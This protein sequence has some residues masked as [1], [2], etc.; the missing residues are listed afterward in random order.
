MNAITDSP[1]MIR[2]KKRTKRD[3]LNVHKDGEMGQKGTKC[4][5]PFI[6]VFVDIVN[7]IFSF[8]SRCFLIQSGTFYERQFLKL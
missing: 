7:F 4:V 5:V 8:F 3:P 2:K 6:N 1:E